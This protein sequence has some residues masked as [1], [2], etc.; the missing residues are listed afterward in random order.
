MKKRIFPILFFSIL[1]CFVFSINS[2]ARTYM[3]METLPE[4][5]TT[6]SDG[7][8]VTGYFVMEYIGTNQNSYSLYLVSDYQ[9]TG[10]KPQLLSDEALN[11]TFIK[12]TNGEKFKIQTLSNSDYGFQIGEGWSPRDPVT[13]DSYVYFNNFSLSNFA[14]FNTSNTDSY[15][16][17]HSTF[18]FVKNDGTVF[19][20]QPPTE[21]YQI[22]HKVT[23]EGLE[24]RLTL[25]GTI[26]I[27]V[28]CGVGLIALLMV[29]NLFGKV[30]N[31]YRS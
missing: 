2:F 23:E 10:G 27:L 22:I 3:T 11:K 30:F 5:P 21:L 19:F 31:H 6:L 17:V 12:L 13:T 25:A 24:T 14:K 15:N 9:Q 4:I 7:S 18:D 8:P 20:Q 1:F 26:R 16:V 29:L 28:L